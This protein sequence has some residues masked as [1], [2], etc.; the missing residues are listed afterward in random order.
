MRG[1]EAFNESQAV[2]AYRNGHETTTPILQRG[3]Y[4]TEVNHSTVEVHWTVVSPFPLHEIVHIPETGCASFTPISDENIQDYATRL[5]SH[6]IVRGVLIDIQHVNDTYTLHMGFGIATTHEAVFGALY[7]ANFDPHQ[8]IRAATTRL[9]LPGVP[10][11][12]QFGASTEHIV[13]GNNIELYAFNAPLNPMAKQLI[14]E[15]AI[16]LARAMQRLT[17]T[18]AKTA[19]RK[20]WPHDGHTSASLHMPPSAFIEI[21]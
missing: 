13:G 21:I 18:V 17:P 14:V 5:K 11:A 15:Q 4:Q 1:M 7:E 6:T 9:Q 8:L 19:S 12:T 3:M 10:F 16:I 2:A 20:A